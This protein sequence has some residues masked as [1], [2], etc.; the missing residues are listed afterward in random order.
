MVATVKR[1]AVLGFTICIILSSSLLS[2]SNINIYRGT[3][4]FTLGGGYIMPIGGFSDMAEGGPGM[5]FS[6][7]YQ[8]TESQMDSLFGWR[9][10]FF[11][12][13]FQ[14]M[15]TPPSGSAK[16]TMHW[17]SLDFG[18]VAYYPLYRWVCPYIGASAGWHF[19]TVDLDATGKSENSNGF[20]MRGKGGIVIPATSSLSFRLETSYGFCFLKP[21]P[22]SSIGFTLGASYNFSG[23]YGNQIS[24]TEAAVKIVHRNL[25]E[26]YAIRY[27]QYNSQGIGT[28]SIKNTGDEPLYNIRIDTDIEDVTSESRSTEPVKTLSPGETRTLFVPVSITDKILSITE[29]GESSVRFRVVFG[30]SDSKYYYK[31]MSKILMYNKNA[32]TWDKT[33]RLG[34]FIMPR[35]ASVSSYGRRVL[36]SVNHSAGKGISN[37][38]FTAMVLFDSLNAGGLSYV[39]D[40]R[41]TFSQTSSGNT[42]IDYVQLPGE[43]LSKK[44]GDCDDLTVLYA[45]LLESVGISTAIITV[46]GHVFLMF[47]SEVIDTSA[48]EVSDNPRDY[49]IREGTVWI[50]VEVT[51]VREGFYTAWK[52]GAT[53]KEHAGFACID[54]LKAWEE[55]PPADNETDI[56][57]DSPAGDV[58]G[59]CIKNDMDK[60][61]ENLF[62][63]KVKQLKEVLAAN[64]NAFRTWNE[65]GVTYGRFNMLNEAEECFK[66][67][68]SINPSYY[69][70]TCNLGNIAMLRKDYAAAA[71]YYKKALSLNG[72]DINAM[73][74]Y[75]RALYEMKQYDEASALYKKVILKNP[76]V[77]ARYGYLLGN[78]GSSLAY[79][80]ASYDADRNELNAWG[81]DGLLNPIPETSEPEQE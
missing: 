71:G 35:D 10:Y 40:P 6:C 50:P 67:A 8:P 54:T 17:Y 24:S 58:L 66:K 53:G 2:A 28:L 45:S 80:R 11:E 38:I 48:C 37:K 13:T 78:T 31:E 75:A 77:G 70:A 44:A 63:K 61:R 7:Q 18:P 49:V 16:S 30:S 21:T 1:S 64:G 9:Y 3:P 52:E 14:F 5:Y 22:F 62:D 25:K 46:P 20:M 41:N 73:I 34:S 23:D 4:T 60:I 15:S 69:H 43:T 55:F 26:L 47:N 65:L 27:K 36:S 19:S 57:I 33:E 81:S 32:I 51:M 68:V 74:N 29:N 76:G 12:G 39:S 56:S 59:S 72:E 42:A 79:G